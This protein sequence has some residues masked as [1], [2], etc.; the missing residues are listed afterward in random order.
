[1]TIDEPVQSEQQWRDL[2]AAVLLRA[3]RDAK[4]TRSPR[5]AVEAR[6]WLTASGAADYLSLAEGAVLEWTADL[7]PLDWRAVCYALLDVIEEQ[8]AK[9]AEAGVGV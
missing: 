4:K 5:L 3:L 9:Q 2:L 8:E 6:R 7:A 1:M